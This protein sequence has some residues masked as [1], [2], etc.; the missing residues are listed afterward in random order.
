[1]VKGW[2]IFLEDSP[3]RIQLGLPASRD[4]G[5]LSKMFKKLHTE[6]ESF[7]CEPIHVAEASI[8][9][10]ASALYS[11][12]IHEAFDYLQLSFFR[13]PKWDEYGF[14]FFRRSLCS[15]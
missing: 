15:A 14:I 7:I 4:I 3:L 8:P 9:D 6:A 2:R 11:K 1:M 12:D 5:I 10:F 13:F